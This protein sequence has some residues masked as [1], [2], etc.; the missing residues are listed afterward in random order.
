MNE[1]VLTTPRLELR[2]LQ[3][4]DFEEYAAMHA[5]FEV[6]RYTTRTQLTRLDAWRHLAMIVGHWQLRGFGMWGVEELAT[7]HLVGRVGFYQPDG[8][9]DFELG[10][11]I[12]RNWWGKGYASEA[13]RRCL[14]F[15][16]DDLQR[17]RVIS[18]IDPANTASIRVAEA[19]GET[20]EGE[21]EAGGHRVLQYAMRRTPR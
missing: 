5:D 19:I 9:P 18:L 10:W 7:G 21:V 1:P 17:D 11:T 12:G 16:F 2:M 6:T 13:A 4:S 14:R 15:A 8:W 3:E 20:L